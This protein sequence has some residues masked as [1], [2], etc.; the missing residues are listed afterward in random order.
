MKSNDI[1]QNKR[2]EIRMAMQSAIK[3]GNT[4]EF[5]Q[6]FDKMLEV[7]GEDVAAQYEQKLADL[8][9]EMD[10]RILTARG[11]RQ[12]TSQEHTYYQKL[13]EAMGAADPKQAL[14]N[15]D[16]VMPETIIDSVFE[17]LR[18][19]HPLLSKINFMYTGAAVKMLMNTNGYQEAVWGKLTAE[20]VKQLTSGFKEVDTTL[21]KLS[22]FLPVSKAMLDLGP[23]WLDKY[24]RE[25]LY[26]ASANGWEV[27]IVSGNGKDKPIGMM[28]QVGDDV[29]ITA[30]E[31]PKKDAIQ[32][33]AID[34]N[35]IGNLLGM[36]SMDTNGKA[37]QVKEVI[38]IVNHQD[39]FTKVMP[40]TTLLAPDGTYRNDV[41]PYPMS[42]IPSGAVDPGEAVIGL[43][44]RYFAL[45]GTAKDGKIEYSDHYHFLEDERVYLIKLY[46]NG[47]AKDN[48]AFLLLDISNLQPLT[49]KVVQMDAVAAS[50]VAKLAELKIGTLA[51]TP[52]FA[53]DTTNYTVETENATNVVRAVATDAAA[54]VEITVN[55]EKIENGTAAEWKAG[56]NSV[57]V[58]VTAADGTTKATYTVTVTK[59]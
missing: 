50:T 12:L 46:G 38:F 8:Q 39:Y 40:A 47:M 11:V 16:V 36:L 56:E 18:T 4:E 15:L 49:W 54:E 13:A 57:K 22:A 20:I 27:G 21:F 6:Q 59:S 24:I 25:V 2:L 23:V 45:A 28:R 31:Y 44:Y 41:M 14:A 35:T 37:R 19:N 3:A 29:V 17:D 58:I 52:D 33:N 43:A 48:N 9:Q 55:G 51:L 10:S 53:A 42:I 5:Y 26:E 7:I 1:I 30:G 34:P 32:L